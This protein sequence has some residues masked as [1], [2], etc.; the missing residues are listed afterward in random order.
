MP[1]R[2]R[3]GTEV[4]TTSPLVGSDRWRIIELI[5]YGYTPRQAANDVR[6]DPK[7]VANIVALYLETGDVVPRNAS[8]NWP[9]DHIAALRRIIDDYSGLFLRE[10]T[11]TLNLEAVVQRDRVLDPYSIFG[12]CRKLIELKL[13]RKVYKR[14]GRLRSEEEARQFE[15][16]MA[17][18]PAEC[19]IC[20][21]ETRFDWRQLVREYGRSAPGVA[22]VQMNFQTWGVPTTCLAVCSVTGIMGYDA[23]PYGYDGPNLLLAFERVVLPHVGCYPGPNSVL[24][25]DH[26][27]V[28][29][30]DRMEALV[31]AKGGI[32]MGTA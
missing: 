12:V 29:L 13:R 14:R 28:H 3:S 22:P 17:D 4:I 32:M 31:E 30:W 11:A 27:P 19:T 24:I 2:R 7:T 15:L 1:T 10:I 16:V 6:C 8:K 26:A 21:D 5:T 25:V 9:A 18:I 20:A 23:I